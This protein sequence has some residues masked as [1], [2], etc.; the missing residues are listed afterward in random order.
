STPS[1]RITRRRTED[2][3]RRTED[4]RQ[5]T[6]AETGDSEDA[7]TGLH[8]SPPS[9]VFRSPSS[10]LRLPSSVLRSPSSALAP[11]RGR[12]RFRTVYDVVAPFAIAPGADHASALDHFLA[13]VRA[14]GQEL[15][16]EQEEAILELFAGRNVILTTPTGSGKSLVATAFHVRALA[17]GQRSV[18][19]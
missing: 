9:S 4:R 12:G 14:R 3:G 1:R 13:A 17:A 6:E 15:Y 18:Y 7:S 10:V 5:K 11:D 16:P 19:S 8:F 2:R